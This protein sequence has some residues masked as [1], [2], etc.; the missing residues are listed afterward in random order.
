MREGTVVMRFLLFAVTV[1][2]AVGLAPTMAAQE[3][4][5]YLI[6]VKQEYPGEDDD[7]EVIQACLMFSDEAPGV[8]TV[9]VLGEAPFSGVWAHDQLN[10]SK[11]FWQALMLGGEDVMGFHGKVMGGGKRIKGDFIDGQDGSTGTFKGKR[12]ADCESKLD[13]RHRPRD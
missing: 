7:G 1:M 8:W 5:T 9:T 2:L 6:N 3:G 10:K 13:D 12:D 11:K 4:E